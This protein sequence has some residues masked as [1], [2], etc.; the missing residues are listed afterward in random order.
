MLPDSS[1]FGRTIT[2]DGRFAPLQ[3]IAMVGDDLRFWHEQSPAISR[4]MN[5]V[6][7]KAAAFGRQMVAELGQ[8][9]VAIVG[10]SGTGSPLLEQ[11]GRLGFGR[12]VTIDPQT[13]E[14]RDVP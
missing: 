10:A 3:M 7:R 8:L 1:L 14:M 6:G 9:S 2:D 5:G 12:I 4:Q 13:A 11:A